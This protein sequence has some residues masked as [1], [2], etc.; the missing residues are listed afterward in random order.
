MDT[1][2]EPFDFF[3][4]L[5]LPLVLPDI[6]LN[7]DAG[8]IIPDNGDVASV[9]EEASDV[10]MVSGVVVDSVWAPEVGTPEDRL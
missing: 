6:E 2:K 5:L 3:I 10:A 4:A 9:L 8:D 1:Q 7:G